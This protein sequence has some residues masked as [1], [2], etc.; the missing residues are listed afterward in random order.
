M[1]RIPTEVPD[2]H[3]MLRAKDGDIRAFD[4]LVARHRT[5]VTGLARRACGPD[6]ADEVA[7]AAF[8]SLWQHRSK[9][10]PERGSV[11]TWLLAIV[12]N[13]G[14]DLMRSRASRQRLVVAADPHGWMVA[15]AGEALVDEAPHAQ[16]ERAESDAEVS[17]LLSTLPPAQRVVIELAYLD[18]LSQQQ[19]ARAL[20][21]PLGTVKGRPRLGL[22]KPRAA[23][24]E[25]PGSEPLLAAA[26]AD[27]RCAPRVGGREGRPPQAA[28]SAARVARPARPRHA[29]GLG[30][31][32]RA[33][34]EGS[35]GGCGEA[36]IAPCDEAGAPGLA[37]PNPVPGREREL[38]LSAR[39]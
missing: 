5:A 27:R 31:L 13:R 3:L 17:R 28:A 11:R 22:G 38:P 4:V 29:R 33:A 1:R 18:G 25:D 2:E 35:P 30:W 19:I 9:Y 15:V 7:Q 10:R 6:L 12:R 32:Q 20:K 8:M 36:T 16:V 34:V 23:G 37:A 21:I 39:D 14:I 24:E 26:W